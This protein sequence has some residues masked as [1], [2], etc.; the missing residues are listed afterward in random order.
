MTLSLFGDEVFDSDIE[1]VGKSSV[2]PV[3]LGITLVLIYV[4]VTSVMARNCD[5]KTMGKIF[6]TVG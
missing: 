3:T 4:Y 6:L 1:E 5:A 2:V